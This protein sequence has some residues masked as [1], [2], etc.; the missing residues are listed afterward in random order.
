MRKCS[1]VLLKID[2]EKAFDIVSWSFL[3]DLL[4]YSGFSRLWVNW[5]SAI[6]S[7]ASTR[8]LLNRN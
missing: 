6:L 7:T 1:T 4:R 5:I 3:L 2:I 8:I